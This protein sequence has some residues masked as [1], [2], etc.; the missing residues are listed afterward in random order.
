[1]QKFVQD[2]QLMMFKTC[3]KL[4]MWKPR[5]TLRMDDDNETCPAPLA[6]NVTNIGT[7]E[8]EQHRAE[9]ARR[10]RLALARERQ[11]EKRAAKCNRSMKRKSAS[12]DERGHRKHKRKVHNQIS[13]KTIS[14]SRKDHVSAKPTNTRMTHCTESPTQQISRISPPLWQI[15]MR[16][17]VIAFT[18]GGG[19]TNK[20]LHSNAICQAKRKS[21]N[22]KLQL[23]SR[24]IC[25][26]SKRGT[27]PQQRKAPMCKMRN[28]APAEHQ[29]EAN[30]FCYESGRE[31]TTFE[32]VPSVVV[33]AAG[34]LLL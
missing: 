25:C 29:P 12:V 26:Q 14:Q 9:V 20:C 30:D 10:I 17:G 28:R 19:K 23:P 22:I 4:K 18:T 21:N 6:A 7:L 33:R 13:E 27:F 11:H 16:G 3:K 5:P 32:T 2:L 15:A 24:E 8:A 31:T 1:M 34:K